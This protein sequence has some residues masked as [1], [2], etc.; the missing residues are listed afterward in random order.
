VVVARFIEE[1][2]LI[3]VEET[4]HRLRIEV[5]DPIGQQNNGPAE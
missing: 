4:M 3:G 5:E 2:D 1:H